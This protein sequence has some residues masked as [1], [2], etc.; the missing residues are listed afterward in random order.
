M[1]LG[2]TIHVPN[3]K[4]NVI[5]IYFWKFKAKYLK[6]SVKIVKIIAIEI[7]QRASSLNNISLIGRVATAFRKG[8]AKLQI[9]ILLLK[10]K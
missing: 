3:A 9:K 2:I 1:W 6:G 7:I 8:F 5:L 4:L 10:S